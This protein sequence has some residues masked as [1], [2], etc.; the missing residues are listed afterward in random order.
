M[1]GGERTKRSVRQ[2]H[3]AIWNGRRGSSLNGPRRPTVASRVAR[4]VARHRVGVATVSLIAVTFLLASVAV[5]S[6]MARV[7]RLEQDQRLE[8]AVA[9]GE[10]Q[11]RWTEAVEA[12]GEALGNGHPDP[13]G[14]RVRRA[15]LLLALNRREEFPPFRILQALDRGTHGWV[16]FVSAAACVSDENVR[17]Y[18][19]RLGGLLALLYAI[20]AVDFHFDRSL[21][22]A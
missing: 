17:L 21:A 13:L 5:A 19:R 7:R 9:D 16:E 18:H 1:A 22:I 6:Q 14:M 4:Y 20:G 3:S 2:R 11:G 10:R 12:V 8:R 15:R